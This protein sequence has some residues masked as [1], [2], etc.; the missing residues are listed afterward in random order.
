MK[1]VY[2]L[3][4]G[5]EQLQTFAGD[6]DG[7]HAAVGGFAGAGGESAF[8]EAIGEAGDVGVA[9]DHAVS[10]LAA[11]ESVVA[12]SAEDTEHVVLGGGN[13]EGFEEGSFLLEEGVGCAEEV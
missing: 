4:E 3:V 5:G 1:F 10:D 11:R 2:R 7:D 6:A 13:A 12:G 9:G 8:F